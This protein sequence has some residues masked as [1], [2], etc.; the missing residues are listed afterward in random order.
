MISEQDLELELVIVCFIGG[1]VHNASRVGMRQRGGF[2]LGFEARI[3]RISVK[4]TFGST[5]F[6]AAISWVSF[7]WEWV[8][9][10]CLEGVLRG[11]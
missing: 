5:F 3:P 10:E 7:S 9:C 11:T 8:V 2:K 1:K 6:A 4:K